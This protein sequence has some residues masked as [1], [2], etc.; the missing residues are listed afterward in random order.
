MILTYTPINTMIKTV[1]RLRL[2]NSADCNIFYAPLA[3][4]AAADR[5]RRHRVQGDAT[6]WGRFVRGRVVKGP[7]NEK[8][9]NW[10][11]QVHI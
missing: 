9:G 6:S 5:A 3:D 11:I 7:L 4:L 1:V 10:V 8:E 2:C